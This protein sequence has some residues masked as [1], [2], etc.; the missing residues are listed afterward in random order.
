M[1][2]SHLHL[3]LTLKE[4]KSK[5]RKKKRRGCRNERDLGKRRAGRGKHA[6]RELMW[7]PEVWGLFWW[8]FSSASSLASVFSIRAWDSMERKE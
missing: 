8:A 6:E 1:H 4:S 7:Y 3:C 5:N 2:T